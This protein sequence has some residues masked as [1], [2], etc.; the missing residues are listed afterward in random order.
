[1]SAADVLGPLGL[2]LA[3][4]GMA[5]FGGTAWTLAAIAIATLGVLFVIYSR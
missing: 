4:V 5:M 3:L 1:M 2:G